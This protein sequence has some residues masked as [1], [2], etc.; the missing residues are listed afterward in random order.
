MTADETAPEEVNPHY[1]D[2][3]IRVSESRAVEAAEDIVSQNG[4]KLLAKGARINDK[5]RERL[6]MHKLQKPLEDCIQVTQGVMP[7][8]FGPLGEALFE[9]H[10]LLKALCAHDLYPSAPKTLATLKLS[11]PVQSLLT[12]YAEHQGER[13]KHTAGVAMLALALARRMLPGETERH[14]MLALAGLLHDVGELYIDPQFMRPGTPLGPPEWRHV[15][16]HPIVAERV[17]RNMPGAGKEIASAVLHHHERLDGFGYP[18]GVQGTALPLN[19]QILAAAEWLM[20]LIETSM[21]PITRA[22]VATRLIPGEFSRELTEAIAAAALADTS[23]AAVVADPMP[24]ES[25]IPRVIGIASTLERFREARP[26]IDKHIAAARPG[27]RAV[28]EAGLQRLLRIQTAFS[29]T[30]LDTHDPDALVAGLAE[31]R[32]PE[33]QVELMTVVGELEW[34]LRELE[35]ESLLRAGLLPAEESAVMRE[36]IGKLKG[37]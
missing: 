28:L 22:S 25:A 24:L 16:S 1:L 15:A 5:V 18:R 35:R 7:E 8:S 37:E 36:L 32:D 34:R 31:Q 33:L 6:L 13:L 19:G 9:Q 26:W 12:V 3:V 11:I 10:P 17:L 4:I 2:H 20:A 29:S 27:L 21:T 14:R 30:G 23:P